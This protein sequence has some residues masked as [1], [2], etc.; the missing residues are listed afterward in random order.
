MYAYSKSRRHIVGCAVRACALKIYTHI[1]GYCRYCIYLYCANTIRT[2]AEFAY[3]HIWRIAKPCNG[4]LPVRKS[5]KP[6]A[7]GDRRKLL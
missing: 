4:Q 7:K 6:I 1:S 3:N 2:I 5:C